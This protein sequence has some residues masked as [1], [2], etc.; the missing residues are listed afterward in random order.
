MCGGCHV[1][2][3]DKN[4]VCI[5]PACHKLKQRGCTVLGYDEVKED[6]ITLPEM[7]HLT[8]ID[9]PRALSVV[10]CDKLVGIYASGCDLGSIE[11]CETLYEVI[12]E[13]QQIPTHDLRTGDA[14]D[15]D[16]APRRKIDVI[17][18][19]AKL[20]HVGGHAVAGDECTGGIK[21]HPAP[22]VQVGLIERCGS[23]KDATFERVMVQHICNVNIYMIYVKN[24]D[25]VRITRCKPRFGYMKTLCTF[26][27]GFT[28]WFMDL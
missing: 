20:G 25:I 1:Y 13:T 4:H 11:N 14:I 19:C 7:R 8:V 28:Y 22:K 21:L 12:V 17:R 9:Y 5:G 24:V 27:D 23:G 3:T 6:S 2:D 16:D 18:N 10:G 15:V 26:P